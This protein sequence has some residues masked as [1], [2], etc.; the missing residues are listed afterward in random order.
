MIGK[1]IQELCGIFWKVVILR[2]H[3]FSAA[4]QQWRRRRQAAGT[5]R[6]KQH[7]RDIRTF[8]FI[9]KSINYYLT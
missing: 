3:T 6:L 1:E 2:S 5:E 7:S 4:A 9:T 8:S